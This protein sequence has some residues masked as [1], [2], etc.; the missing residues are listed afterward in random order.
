MNISI[1]IYRDR[2][3]HEIGNKRKQVGNFEENEKTENRE[4]PKQIYI[5][6]FVK[7]FI[8]F[9][10]NELTLL[11]T[12]LFHLCLCVI[13]IIRKN[14]KFISCIRQ[15]YENRMVNKERKKNMK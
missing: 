1:S 10:T 7:N 14:C 3:K 11:C 12:C 5:Q 2:D 9:I 8:S 15:R 6:K 4:N 13:L